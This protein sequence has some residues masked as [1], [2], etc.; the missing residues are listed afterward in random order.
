MI[1]KLLKSKTMLIALAIE[2]LGVIQLN[3]DFL[4]TVMTP[5]QFGWVMIGIGVAMKVLRS[6]TTTAIGDK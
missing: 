1:K 4:S 5:A 6:V 3:A 2:L